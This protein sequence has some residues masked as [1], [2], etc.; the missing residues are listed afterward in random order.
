VAYSPAIRFRIDLPSVFLAGAAS[1]HHVDG[2]TAI[3]ARVALRPVER[4]DFSNGVN[5]DV[6]SLEG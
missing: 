4:E 3:I 1:H 5:D 6:G 2:A